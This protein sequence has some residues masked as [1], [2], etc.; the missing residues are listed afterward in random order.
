MR[1]PTIKNLGKRT[2]EHE[3]RWELETMNIQVQ[4]V[5][6]IRGSGRQEGLPPDTIIHTVG[7]AGPRRGK[8][9][10]AQR[11]LLSVD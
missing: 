9:V 3:V 10:F 7:D 5:M 8:R 11:T 4:T 1:M 6:Q 2:P